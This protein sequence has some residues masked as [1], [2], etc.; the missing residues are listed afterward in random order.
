MLFLFYFSLGLDRGLEYNPPGMPAARRFDR[1]TPLILLLAAVLLAFTGLGSARAPRTFHTASRA[2]EERIVDLGRTALVTRIC[3]YVGLGTGAYRLELAAAGPEGAAGG[4]HPALRVEQPD[5][6]GYVEWRAADVGAAGAFARWL[7]LTADQPGLMLGEIGLFGPGGRPLQPPARAPGAEALFD[8]PGIVPFTPG[9]RTGLYFDETYFAR[10]AWELRLG[11]PI[12]ES[13]HPPLGKLL[14]AGGA[15]LFGDNPFGWRF[16]GALAGALAVP[17]LYLLA[18]RLFRRPESA[19]AAALLFLFDFMRFVQARMAT[20]EP[21][22][23]LFTLLA[24]FL[25]HGFRNLDPGRP[26]ERGRALLLALAAGAAVGAAAA[27]KWSGAYA[28]AGL[29]LLWAAAVRRRRRPLFPAAGTVVAL[30]AGA[31]AAYLASYL[32]G[33]L[34]YGATLA[35]V[36]RHQ[37]LMFRYHS[38]VTETRWYASPW[39]QWPPMVRP[40]W[41]YQGRVDVPARAVASIV[42]LG[43]PVVWW[44]GALALLVVAAG[45][46]VRRPG[47]ASGAP[48]PAAGGAGRDPARSAAFFI[49][50]GFL[51][52]LLPW[53][54]APRKLTFLYHYLPCVPFLALALAWALDRLVE[55]DPCWRLALWSAVGAAALL[56]LAYYPLLTGLTVPRSYAAALRWLPTWIFYR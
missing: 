47:A 33:L 45:A 30:A 42:T 3:V 9:A 29:A 28:A 31:A 22:V 44:G 4:W 53:A 7:R 19:L 1:L 40:V 37:A 16:A 35:D 2:G 5:P 27:C 43:N 52:Q 46:I 17:L 8:E 48:V 51:S 23:L 49:L 24:F 36:A 13:T 15:A 54:V 26:G 21:F 38:L 32:P 25:M 41:L 6:F 56:F 20:V 12:S 10:A 14:I 55:R 18:R 50:V 34:R 11:R 39:W